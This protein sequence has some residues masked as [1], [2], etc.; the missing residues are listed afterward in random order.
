[1][2]S[3]GTINAAAKQVILAVDEDE[4]DSVLWWKF[5]SPKFPKPFDERKRERQHVKL[6]YREMC[7][8]RVTCLFRVKIWV[9]WFKVGRMR[10]NLPQST[11]RVEHEDLQISNYVLATGRGR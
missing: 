1:M 9:F 11:R 6:L 7:H 8:Y 4:A 2:P 5:W 10:I 3:V